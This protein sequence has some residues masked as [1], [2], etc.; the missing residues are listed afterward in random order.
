MGDLLSERGSISKAA[1]NRAVLYGE[2]ETAA[3][4]DGMR[5]EGGRWNRG[6]AQTSEE[7]NSRFHRYTAAAAAAAIKSS[8]EREREAR[9]LLRPQLS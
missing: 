1:D 7:R 3:S 9:L 2:N 4:R 6:P 8:A 5:E